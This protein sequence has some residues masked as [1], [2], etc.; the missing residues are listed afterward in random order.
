MSSQTTVQ[1]RSVATSPVVQPSNVAARKSRANV[2]QG[3]L[4]VVT[5]LAIVILAVLIWDIASSGARWLSLDLLTN[6][7]SRKPEEAG[8]RPA[9]LG[10]LWVI[11]LTALFAFPVGVGAA[12]YL[13]EYAPNNR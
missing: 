12:V 4:F 6:T 1:A 8:L 2:V 3:L 13:E 7:P 11:G 9:L 10:T 5:A